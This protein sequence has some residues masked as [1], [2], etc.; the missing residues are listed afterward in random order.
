M[1]EVEKGHERLGKVAKLA[2]MEVVAIFGETGCYYSTGPSWPCECS[3]L[4][5]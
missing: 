3:V 5:S 1:V 4:V 2:C